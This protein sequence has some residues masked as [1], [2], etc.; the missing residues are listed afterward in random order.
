[1]CSHRDVCYISKW[2]YQISSWMYKSGITLCRGSSWQNSWRVTSL[3]KGS[4]ITGVDAITKGINVDK[5][6]KGLSW[7]G[8]WDS[9]TFRDLGSK[10]EQAKAIA[11]G[12]AARAVGEDQ[13]NVVSWK[14]GEGS[15]S[16]VPVSWAYERP[17][18]WA[19]DSATWMV[20]VTLMK[21]WLEWV[22]EGWEEQNGRLWRQTVLTWSLF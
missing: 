19:L 15:G 21:T 3:T 9:P 6:E 17:D 16:A 13:E 5:K 20:L 22:Q 1:M 18:T 4:K 10:E 11:M 7:T 12:G 14:P 8:H 2:G